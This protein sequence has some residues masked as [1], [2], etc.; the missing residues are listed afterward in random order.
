[1]PAPPAVAH[2]TEVSAFGLLEIAVFTTPAAHVMETTHGSAAQSIPLAPFAPGL[3]FLSLE[4]S[5]ERAQTPTMFPVHSVY[6][7]LFVFDQPCRMLCLVTLFC[8][9]SAPVLVRL[10]S[11]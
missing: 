2:G 8:S 9:G 5:S 10:F 6:N 4:G 7:V 3:P 1:M 11:P